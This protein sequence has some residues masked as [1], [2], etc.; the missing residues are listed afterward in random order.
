MKDINAK[1]GFL[2][3]M[4][5]QYRGTVG[6][7][8]QTNRRI[9]NKSRITININLDCQNEEKY[10]FYTTQDTRFSVYEYSGFD[11]DKHCFSVKTFDISRDV[12]VLNGRA[13]DIRKKIKELDNKTKIAFM[14][15]SD[16]DNVK[17]EFKNTYSDCELNFNHWRYDIVSKF[18]QNISIN[19]DDADR[20]ISAKET[21]GLDK[22]E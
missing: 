4:K 10:I 5:E 14:Y 16:D 1:S 17:E 12:E 13:E 7:N 11:D 3:Y 22:D 6:Q 9:T 15:D 18:S 19:L 2:V 21:L 8:T 20:C